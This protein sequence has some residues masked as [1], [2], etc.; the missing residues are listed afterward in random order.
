MSSKLKILGYELAVVVWVILCINISIFG[1][2]QINALQPY[3]WQH[4][5]VNA[6]DVIIKLKLYTL[7]TSI[8]SHSQLSHLFS[9]CIAF[10]VSKLLLYS[11]TQY[12][13]LSILT[14][15]EFVFIYLCAEVVSEIIGWRITYLTATNNESCIVALARHALGASGAVYTLLTI[16]TLLLS[17]TG[18]SLSRLVFNDINFMIY[19]TKLDNSTICHSAHL[20]HCVVFG[21]LVTY[22]HIK[23]KLYM[24]AKN[25]EILDSN[26]KTVSN[27]LK[28][29]QY[30]N[31]KIS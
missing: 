19:S 28:Q 22:L 10:N 17:Q 26:S 3:I 11:T 12:S 27:T 18:Y 20:V 1:L 16:A 14:A 7:I 9:N 13:K 4:F 15:N 29:F 24:Q 6:Y 31:N 23:P 21:L 5:T 8:F 30:I 2:W 25:K